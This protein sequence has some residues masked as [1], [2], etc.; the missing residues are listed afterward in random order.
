MSTQPFSAGPQ[1]H[2]VVVD[3]YRPVRPLVTAIREYGYSCVRVQSTSDTPPVY[4]GP[5]SIADDFVANIVHTGDFEATLDAVSAFDPVAVLAGGEVG[6]EF[7]DRLSEELGLLTNGTAR[8]AARRDKYLMIETLRAAGL[9]AAAQ[10]RVTDEDALRAWHAQRGGRVVVKPLRSAG[11]DGV[12]FCDTPHESVAAFRRLIG[13]SNVFGSVNDGV[14]AQEYL[15]GPEYMVN[16][17]SRDGQHY[18]SDVWHTGRVQ[19]NGM[20]DLCDALSLVDSGGPVVAA[21]SDYAFQV[22]DVLGIRHGPA[23]LEIRLTPSGPCLVEVGARLP[24]GGIAFQAGRSTGD[25]QADLT[26]SAYLEPEKFLAKVGTSYQVSQFCAIV[27]MIS[28]VDGVLRAYRGLDL[29]ERLE[30]FDSMQI[31]VPPGQRIARTVDDLGYP[32]VV[33]LVHESAE[34]VQTAINSVR[35]IDGVGFYELAPA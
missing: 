3:A 9:N 2:I 32:V 33:T 35:H 15:G 16:T 7:A 29:I 10:I 22:L 20:I 13:R 11:G 31:L 21:L 6:V 23:H 24:G 30:G 8:S 18:V 12:V 27:G 26:V 28:P 34:V 4:A 19:A 17:V 25:S 1:A 5:P 14:V